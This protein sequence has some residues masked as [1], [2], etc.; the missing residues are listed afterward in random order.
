ME[1]K[2]KYTIKDC[3]DEIVRLLRLYFYSKADAKEKENILN[4]VEINLR[5]LARC[6]EY[7]AQQAEVTRARKEAQK[8]GIGR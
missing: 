8:L 7:K 3:K 1:V 2:P 5:S 4:N 6:E